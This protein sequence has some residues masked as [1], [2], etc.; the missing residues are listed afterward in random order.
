MGSITHQTRWEQG[1][2][3]RIG[4]AQAKGINTRQGGW[5]DSAGVPVVL[6]AWPAKRAGTWASKPRAQM[7]R[8]LLARL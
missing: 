1:F 8:R 5:R 4:K 3:E 2:L 6:A 7:P